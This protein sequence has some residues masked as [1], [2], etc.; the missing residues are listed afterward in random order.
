MPKFGRDRLGRSIADEIS[1]I[2]RKMSKSIV[3]V[4]AYYLESPFDSI[5]HYDE[6]G[7]EFW[8]GRELQKLLGYRRWDKFIV[9]IET[10]IENLESAI[11]NVT[12][13]VLP[14]G[15]LSTLANPAPLQDYKLSR[16]ALSDYVPSE[17]QEAVYNALV[18]TPTR[19]MLIG[20]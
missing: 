9:V 12:D 18:G 7:T 17:N 10:G 1:K 14:T 15:E 16:I 19:Q 4:S 5:R 6:K 8:K 3:S 13:H 2:T 20:E 11:K